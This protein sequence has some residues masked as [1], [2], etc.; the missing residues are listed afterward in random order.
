V[1]IKLLGDLPVGSSR[2]DEARRAAGYLSKY[3]G[4]AFDDHRVPGLH[5]Y[6]IAQGFKPTRTR[7]YGRTE[8]QALAAACAVMG[9]EPT[10][11]WS[12]AQDPAWDRASW[13]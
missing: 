7:V 13:S 3:V 12:S 10:R 11:L 8:P 4:K 6:E 5:R 9:S 1:H 2:L